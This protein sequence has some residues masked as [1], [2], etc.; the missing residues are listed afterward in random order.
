MD[1]DELGAE[2]KPTGKKIKANINV[3]DVLVKNLGPESVFVECDKD[4]WDDVDHVDICEWVHIEKLKKDYPNKKN[5]ILANSRFRF[6]IEAFEISQPTYMCQVRHFYHKKTKYLP[7]GSYIIYTDDVILYE[8]PNPYKH[9]KIPLVIDKDI[10]IYREVYGR[11]FIT[12]IEQMQRFYNNIQSGMARDIGVGMMPKWMV[13]KGSTKIQSLNNEFTV[14]EYAGAIAPQ[15]VQNVPVSEKLLTVQDRLEMKISKHS[16]VG[17]VSRGEVPAGVTA[18]SALRFLDEQEARRVAPLVRARRARIRNTYK[19]MS[20]VMGQFYQ[21]DDGRTIRVTSSHHQAQLP[22][23]LPEEEYTILGWTENL[24]PF[25]KDGDNNEVNPEKECEDV[26][27]HKADNL[28]IQ[29]HPEWCYPPS[30]PSEIVM[31][32]YYQILLDKFLNKEL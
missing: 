10:E 17:D 30:S 25:H 20:S 3:G 13:P 29:S 24:L 9:G 15:I 26:I 23:N 6:D 19:M 16:L 22:Y 1:V 4:S 32:D 18:N 12:N 8:G 2:G 21:E 5:E 7:D 14:V 11:S 28:G 31:I 27:Y